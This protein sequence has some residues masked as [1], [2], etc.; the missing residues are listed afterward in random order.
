MP[1]LRRAVPASFAAFLVAACALPPPGGP[2]PAETARP[3]A[4]TAPEPRAGL[5]LHRWPAE[6]P[7]RAAI[8]ALHGFGD[9][10]DLAFESAARAWSG[11]GIAVYAP[12]QRGFGANA[13]RK[14]WPGD[15]ALVTD[16][17]A[18]SRAVRALN[19]GMP[20]VVVG[21]SMGGGIALAAAAE[22]LDADALVLSG[23]AI[24]G[25]DALNPLLRAGG[26]AFATVAPDRRWT[27]EGLVAI[28]PTDNPEALARTVAD[29]RHFADPSSRELYGLVRLMDRAA[30]VAPAVQIPTLVLVGARDEV[31][32]PEAITA[33]ARRI[34]GLVAIVDY[35]DGWHWLFRDRQAPRVW[36]DVA[37]FAL[38]PGG[39]RA[40]LAG[41]DA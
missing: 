15:D 40:I 34:P 38:D 19:P 17:V 27:G 22:G 35:A 24:A 9:A 16:A 14:R 21:E 25:G 41:P 5:A 23:P 33:V 10:G 6:G 12:D 1:S 7:T 28:R 30:A 8:L 32:D 37:A 39:G 2:A 13:T 11:R 3:V 18:L 4:A 20:L 29:P 31:L 36:D 26:R